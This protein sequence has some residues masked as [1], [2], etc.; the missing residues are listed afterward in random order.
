MKIFRRTAFIHYRRNGEILEEFK[1]EPVEEIILV[2]LVGTYKNNEQ[3]KDA[4]VMMNYRPH[5]R[6]RRGRPLK[7]L[8]NKAETGSIK[9]YLVT[10]DDDDDDDD[11]IP[12]FMSLIA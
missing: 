2:K 12:T 11:K 6:R 1:V 3:N 7:K 4:K 10:D 9:A 5:G 8:L